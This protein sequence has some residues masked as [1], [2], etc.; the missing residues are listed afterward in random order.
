MANF[1]RPVLLKLTCLLQI[2]LLFAFSSLAQDSL[3]KKSYKNTIR[4]N[5]TNPLLFGSRSLIFGYERILNNRRSFSIN[6]GQ[7]SFPRLGFINSDSIKAN[8]NVEESGFHIS[9]DYRFYLGKENKYASPRGV[10]IGP[11]FAYNYFERKNSLLITSTNGGSPQTVLS[12]TN[13]TVSS[14]GFQL[15][16]Q[17]VFWDRLSLDMILAG[18][19]IAAYNLKAS[20]GANLSEADQKKFFEKLNAALADKFPGYNTV[21]DDGEFESKGST[22]TTSLGYRYMVMIGFRF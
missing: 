8:P 21:F 6:I 15:G 11:Y 2:L 18:P 9:G 4:F 13:L 19:G 1:Q 5:V 3:P 22:S 17:F 12:E 14:L 20:L 16:Y 7:A 10:Y